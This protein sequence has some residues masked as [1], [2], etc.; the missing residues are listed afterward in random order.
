VNAKSCCRYRG[1]HGKKLIA[2]TIRFDGDKSLVSGSAEEAKV[3]SPIEDKDNRQ[4]G[5]NSQAISRKWWDNHNKKISDL[6]L[7]NKRL[8]ARNHSLLVAVQALKKSNEILGKENAKLTNDYCQARQDKLSFLKEQEF[9]VEQNNNLKAELFKTKAQLLKCSETVTLSHPT[10][11][12]QIQKETNR[13]AMLQMIG[14]ALLFIL[15]IIMHKTQ[16]LT[17]LRA[18]IE[19]VFDKELF[20]ST[21]TDHVKREQVRKYCRNTIFLPWKVLQGLDT[22][23]NGGINYNGLEILRSVEQLQHYERGCLPSRSSVQRCADELHKLGQKLVPVTKQLCAVGELF[24]FNYGKMLRF[25]LKTFSLYEIAQRDAVHI[26][27]TLDGAE[28]TKDLSHLT[29][30]VKVTD[31]RA[32]DP[33]DGS[34]LSYNEDGVFGNIFQVQSRNYCFI[35]KSLLGKDNK[36]AYE[37]FH[38]VFKFFDDVMANGL[39]RDGDEP[40]IQPI[41]IWSPQDL[42]SIWKCLN[43]GCGARK[44]GDK[45]WCH[46]CPCT[47]NKIAFYLLDENRC[48]C[49]KAKQRERCY[50]WRVG[51]ED[52][53]AIFQEEL[54]DIMEDYLAT[55][56]KSYEEI[57]MCSKVI[58]NPL[59]VNRFGNKYNIDFDVHH[60]EADDLDIIFFSSLLTEELAIR[61]LSVSGNIHERRGRLLP[62]LMMEQRLKGIK[63][64][65]ERT[66]EG[67]ESALILIKQAIICIM[68]ME[69]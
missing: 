5:R 13:P 41:T 53:I 23:I 9:V 50:H 27:I 32:I 64:S 60:E 20:G 18:V 19:V 6:I 7:E 59:E 8:E 54:E 61:R 12:P 65:I 1:H 29:F 28:L 49:C 40:A 33:R 39:S 25:I 66:K 48:D 26:C 35:M 57:L 4:G 45:H 38:D 30:G 56:G 11:F 16:Q 62:Y 21:S 36:A 3:E 52:S 67:K 58:Y 24:A 14:S 51:D 31:S 2:V 34:P 22:S 17:R 43:T 44:H 69:N 42:S 46:L 10:R 68:H 63:E 15:N 37:H 47:G 55:C